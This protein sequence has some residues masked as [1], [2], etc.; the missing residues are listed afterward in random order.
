MKFNKNFK[1]LSSILLISLVVL[2]SIA[3][4]S[5]KITYKRKL[6]KT[7]AKK[8]D[9]HFAEKKVI[10]SYLAKISHGYAYDANSNQL[11]A[12]EIQVMFPT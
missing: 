12:D 2:S 8:I 9:E 10:F 11:I 4:I 1:T 5:S 3:S 7:K 6:K